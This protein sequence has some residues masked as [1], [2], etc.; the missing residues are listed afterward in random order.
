MPPDLIP[1][2]FNDLKKC[3]LGARN[4]RKKWLF[5][6]ARASRPIISA[7]SS[8]ALPSAL[9]STS[10]GFS[11]IGSGYKKISYFLRKLVEIITKSGN[12]LHNYQN[13]CNNSGIVICFYVYLLF[14]I[15]KFVFQQC[16]Y[17][18]SSFFSR[19][20]VRL[21]KNLADALITIR[22]ND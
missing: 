19:I 21:G 1:R 16:K 4:E 5:P 3:W 11:S 6:A 2:F 13:F 15:R 9:D 7:T 8:G 12:F 17:I 14:Y 10:S 20:N 22:F 18:E